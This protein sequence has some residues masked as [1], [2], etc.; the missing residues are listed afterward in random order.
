MLSFAN[1]RW[2]RLCFVTV[3]QCNSLTW[4]STFLAHEQ[5]C[6]TPVSF[7]NQRRF[8]GMC[9]CIQPM[10]LDMIEFSISF[11][12]TVQSSHDTQHSIHCNCSRNCCGEN[13]SQSCVINIL[14]FMRDST[15]LLAWLFHYSKR[16]SCVDVPTK[17][18][19]REGI[20]SRI[21]DITNIC[22]CSKWIVDYFSVY[23]DWSICRDL[24]ICEEQRFE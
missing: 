4:L 6:G 13:E 24:Q 3:F 7:G 19:C 8:P 12:L 15:V 10:A 18:L 20:Q 9:T 14:V 1:C 11:L 21:S 2:L 17:P 23:T 16:V 22:A 5:L